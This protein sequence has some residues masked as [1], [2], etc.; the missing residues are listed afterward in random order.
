MANAPPT[1]VGQSPDNFLTRPDES[2]ASNTLQ[3][4]VPIAQSTRSPTPMEEAPSAYVSMERSHRLRSMLRISALAVAGLLVLIGAIFVFIQ[5]GNRTSGVQAGNFGTV[6]ISLGKFVAESTGTSASLKV[7]GRLQV[8]N[9]IVLTPTSQPANPVAGQLY[10]DQTSN[11]MRYYNGQQF[12]DLG[13]N[14]A[15]VT[16]IGGSSG[17]NASSVL[18]QPSSPGTLQAGN[19]N[20]SG[21]GMVG[22][23]KTSVIDS[24]G[25]ALFVN[26]LSPVGTTPTPGGTPAILGLTSGSQ[27]SGGTE[28]DVLIATEATMPATGGT[29]K[30]IS[31]FIVGGSP[32]SHIQ[33]GLYE[34]DGDIP[35]KPANRLATSAIVN[36]V[37]N[38]INTLTIPSTSLSPNTTYWLAFNTDDPA[39]KRQYNGGAQV[40]CFI[41]S[42]FGFMPDPFSPTG[43]FNS[44]QNYAIY[45]NYITSAGGGGG[46]FGSA[47]FSLSTTGQ[48]TFQNAEDSPTAFQ[49]QNAT[50][51]TTILNVDTVNGRIAIGKANAAYKLD[52]A[53]G[54]INLS[55]NRSI[56]FGGLQALSSASS[57]TV[58]ALSNFTSGGT[59]VVQG[60]NFSVQDSNGVSNLISVNTK[61]GGDIS[62]TTLATG[63]I[64]GDVSI[65]TGDSAT[66]ASGNI[67]I[68]AGSGI[69]SGTVVGTKTFE[70]GLDNMVNWFGSTVAQSSAQAHGGTN[71]LQM[72]ATA[73]FW[74]VQEDINNP[75][76]T[77]VPGHQYHFS[78]WARAATTP[79][80]ITSLANWVGGGG[81]TLPLQ[82]VTDTTTGWTEITGNG[83]A[84]AGATGV[85]PTMQSTGV[86]GEVHYFDDIV[87][88]D[89]SS[90]SA[91]STI[92]IGDTNAK[93]V[94]IGNIN[95]IG[96]TSII[97]GSGINLTSGVSGITLNGG[98]ISMSGSAAS[99]LSTSSGALTLTSAASAIWGISNASSGVGGTLTLRAGGSGSGNNDGG[100]LVIQGG[101]K[102]GAGSSGSVIVKPQNDV[103]DAF[104]IQNSAGTPLLVADSAGMKIIVVGTDTVFASLTLTDAH[105]ASTQTTAPTIGTPANC[106]TTPS[107]AVTT[108]STDSAGAFSVTTGTGG[109]SSTCD[110]TITFH[111]AYGAAPKS[112]LVVGKTDA[113]SA[114]RQVFVVSANTTNFSV[115][116][117]N[118]AGG[119]DNT[120]YSFSYWV[121]E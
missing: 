42:I 14:A 23:L 5:R 86:V 59:V 21:V 77:V 73:A 95:Q 8:S 74:G 99:S 32:S 70:S 10:Y 117:G 106:G 85:Y 11:Q 24:S 83:I 58:T 118:G 34:D 43:C 93:I 81:S 104:Q 9:S 39:M 90:S 121:I 87:I 30:S 40:S 88:T 26:P 49:I 57:G 79:R 53:G 17:S 75:I 48:A 19:F 60:D 66:T 68:D 1:D 28:N 36:L 31:V 4:T 22:T 33:V 45:A 25:T 116:F 111:Q 107:A 65:K 109:T 94:T 67:T 97:G 98:T 51:T 78:L 115:A 76:T 18:L 47:Q 29:A 120:T 69:I 13:G 82:I 38:A 44:N 114:A 54:D 100:D 80:S 102:S 52:I 103:T 113:A 84:P 12:V 119:A 63:G 20:I 71:S 37:P 35:N 41:S 110:T 7:N 2:L 105:F 61:G 62:L 89:L 27:T 64:S 96:A 108:G 91:A 6:R 46:A 15:N 112:I 72:T 56:R 92:N 16:N 50:G 101:A 3:G 55:N